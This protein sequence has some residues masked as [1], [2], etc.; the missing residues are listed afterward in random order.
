MALV[1][2]T[3]LTIAALVGMNAIILGN[4]REDALRTTETSLS[5]RALTLAEQADRAIH[6]VELILAHIEEDADK[7]GVSTPDQFR[8]HLASQAARDILREH[9]YGQPQ[10][11]GLAV[12]DIKGDIVNSSDPGPLTAVNVSDRGYFQQAVAA[13]APKVLFSKPL[14]RRENGKWTTLLVRRIDNADGEF[15]GVITAAL[16][17]S[18]FEDFYK[19]VS[20]GGDDA[21][22]LLRDDGV[23]L[24]RYPAVD[25]TGETSIGDLAQVPSGNR[26]GAIRAPSTAD[27]T[28]RILAT[29]R[30][31]SYPLVMV[32]SQTQHSA[33]A[34]WR[35]IG[36]LIVFISAA[37][38][39]I[40]LIAAASIALWQNEVEAGSRART[41]RAEAERARA[42]AEAELMREREQVAAAANRAKSDFLATMSHEVRTPMNA[43]IGLTETLLDSKLDSEQRTSVAAMH[44]AG[45]NLLRIV[46][47]IL[48][49]SKLEAGRV[50]FEP[51]VQVVALVPAAGPVPPPSMVVMPLINASS[52]CC[53]QMK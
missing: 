49:F 27:G 45:D 28:T 48:D 20:V 26:S 18:Y 33:L 32:V 29:Q 52:T 41:A 21:F 12:F 5:R 47:D 37:S 16:S 14:Q 42:L 38:A 19:S 43:L 8:Q 24:L 30:L 7:A 11:D 35:E 34:G 31:R 36:Q 23:L 25:P 53:G 50:E 1:I 51:G 3:L 44:E 6:A 22:A 9:L 2:G 39:L 40:L 17:L 13:G 46:N 10:L 4:L 15:I